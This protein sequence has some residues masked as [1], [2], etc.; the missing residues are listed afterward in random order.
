MGIFCQRFRLEA[1]LDKLSEGKD[2]FENEALA[3]EA[4]LNEALPYEALSYEA[5]PYEALSYVVTLCDP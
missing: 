4:I 1:L 2:T 3:Y 5:L